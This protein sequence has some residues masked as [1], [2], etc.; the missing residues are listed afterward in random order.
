MNRV[1]K[2]PLHQSVKGAFCILLGILSAMS[3]VIGQSGYV[4]MSELPAASTSL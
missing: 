4:G 3:F 2:R 1:S